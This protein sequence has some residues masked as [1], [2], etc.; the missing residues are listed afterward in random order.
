M[1]NTDS[2][3][4]PNSKKLLYWGLPLLAV[5]IV[6][7]SYVPYWITEKSWIPINTLKPNEI[8]DT[9]GGTL[10][11]IVGLIASILTFFA[12]WAQFDANIEQRR[13]FN[14]SIQNE[15]LA[16]K[17]E[18]KKN[19]EEQRRLSDDY[20]AQQNQFTESQKQFEKKQKLQQ[21]QIL[22]QDKQ[23]RIT[24]FETRFHTMLSIHRDNAMSM[25]VNKIQGRKV[26]LHMLDELKIIYNIFSLIHKEN[27]LEFAMI[28]EKAIYNVA[29]LSFFFGIGEKSTPMVKDLVGNNLVPFVEKAHKMIQK[30]MDRRNGTSVNFKFGEEEFEWK[31]YS[32]GVGH[33]RRLGH[34]IRHLYQ[35]VKF[36][37]DQDDRLISKDAKYSYIS[38]LRA[39]LSAHEQ[40]LLFYNAISVMGSPW[41][42]PLNYID[43]Y[44]LIKSIPLNAVDFYKK[45]SDFFSDKNSDGKSMFEWVDIRERMNKL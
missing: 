35:T 18:E 11:P 34:Y 23:S 7:L 4:Y 27:K 43:R 21:Q 3:K 44:C 12:F 10:G 26:F 13:Q 36:V 6:I 42:T 22:L 25:E 20:I 9:I 8:G 17:G 5:T 2:P 28:D 37:D 29:Y 32:F 15:A 39:Q 38:N 24:L 1:T 45:P 30:Q 41:L 14:T 40:V 33:L 16:R 19:A 31:V